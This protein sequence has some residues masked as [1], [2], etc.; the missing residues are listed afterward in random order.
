[1]SGQKRKQNDSSKKSNYQVNRRTKPSGITRTT[2]DYNKALTYDC[3]KTDII[4]ISEDKLNLNL[5]AFRESITLK[6]DSYG[7]LGIVI[8]L[9]LVLVTATFPETI[10]GISGTNWKTFIL[11]SFIVALYNLVAKYISYRKNKKSVEEFIQDIKN[12]SL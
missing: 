9:I 7:L 5:Q 11:F 3:T 12:N 1:M 2:K 10:F 8:T 4:K 6:S